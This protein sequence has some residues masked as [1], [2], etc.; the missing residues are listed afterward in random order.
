MID[1]TAEALDLFAAKIHGRGRHIPNM[2]TITNRFPKAVGAFLTTCRKRP[3]IVISFKLI[4]DMYQARLNV[5]T[6]S[7]GGTG[8]R[9]AYYDVSLKNGGLAPLE[10]V[11]KLTFK[12]V[13]ADTTAAAKAWVMK[14]IKLALNKSATVPDGHLIE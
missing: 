5:M 8:L 7:G 13:E 14:Q 11:D 2:A 3:V 10:K 9:V 1:Q 12:N 6:G 4:E